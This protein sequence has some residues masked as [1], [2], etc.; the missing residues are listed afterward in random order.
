MIFAVA[1]ATFRYVILYCIA[2]GL[3]TLGSWIMGDPL[4]DQRT[5]IVASGVVLGLAISDFLRFRRRR[6][7]GNIGL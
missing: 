5:F 7:A 4:F 1:K 2:I 6:K 3:I